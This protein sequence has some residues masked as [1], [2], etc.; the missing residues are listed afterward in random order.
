MYCIRDVYISAN[1]FLGTIEIVLYA[2]NRT[3]EKN[4]KHLIFSTFYSTDI[5]TNMRL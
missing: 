2:E 1:C 4:V 3:Q 5:N